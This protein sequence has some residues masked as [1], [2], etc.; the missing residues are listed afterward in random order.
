MSLCNES[1]KEVK[2]TLPEHY[3]YVGMI[4]NRKAGVR[5]DLSSVGPFSGEPSPRASCCS[6]QQGSPGNHCKC[7]VFLFNLQQDYNHGQE[8]F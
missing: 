2:S 6:S 1:Q 4:R 7:L 5:G 8:F 3:K